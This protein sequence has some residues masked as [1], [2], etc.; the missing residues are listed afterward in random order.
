MLYNG[1]FQPVTQ[2]AGPEAS[3][4]HL[5]SGCIYIE[6]GQCWLSQSPGAQSC[7]SFGP[8]WTLGST[9]GSQ[10]SAVGGVWAWL[11]LRLAGWGCDSLLPSHWVPYWAVPGTPLPVAHPILF[12]HTLPIT[13]TDLSEMSQPRPD[14]NDPA[15]L[16]SPFAMNS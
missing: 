8:T 5:E 10:L 12:P 9:K 11:S 3:C 2:T 13:S 4:A 16:P 14:S 7:D 1:H 6:A 15:A